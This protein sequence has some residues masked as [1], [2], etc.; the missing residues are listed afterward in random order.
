[1]VILPVC[2]KCKTDVVRSVSGSRKNIFAMLYVSV[3]DNWETFIQYYS[4][5]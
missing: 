5:W 4:I 1:M 2:S 3:C